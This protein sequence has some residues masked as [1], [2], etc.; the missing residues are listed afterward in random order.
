MPSPESHVAAELGPVQQIS[1]P[2][3]FGTSDSPSKQGR[4]LVVV[5]VRLEMRKH[6]VWAVGYLC[7]CSFLNYPY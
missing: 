2:P 6:P 1:G 5:E 7:Y 4:F 3:S